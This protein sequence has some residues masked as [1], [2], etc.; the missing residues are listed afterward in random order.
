MPMARPVVFETFESNMAGSPG[1]TLGTQVTASGS[2]N[3]KGSYAQLIAAT[4]ADCYF[5][6]VLIADCATSASAVRALVDIAIGGAGSEKVI[7]PNLLA[8]MAGVSSGQAR[9]KRFD[10][11]VFVKAGSRI[12]ARIQSSVASKT[13]SVAVILYEAPQSPA[14][15]GGQVVAYGVST[16]T[17]GGTDVV[18]GTSGAEGSYTTIGTTSQSHRALVAACAGTNDATIV[19]ANMYADLAVGA[20]PTPVVEGL[21]VGAVNSEEVCNPVP[22]LVPTSVPA[23]EALK[24]RLSSEGVAQ[25]LDFAIY[26]I[27]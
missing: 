8:G 11:P 27:S 3:T 12:S 17:S 1:A 4:A 25:T 20:T 10:F 6:T 16:G 21:Y 9:P 13:A 5:I 23:S 15:A 22:S 7:L 2:T 14:W 18:A 26:G 19:S 24:V